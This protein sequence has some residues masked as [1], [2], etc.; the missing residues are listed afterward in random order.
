[1]AEASAER[2]SLVG[3][4]SVSCML[5]V[6]KYEH[7]VKAAHVNGVYCHIG[8]H[9]YMYIELAESTGK[10]LAKYWTYPWLVFPFIEGCPRQ[11]SFPH[12]VRH[13]GK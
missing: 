1:M 13:T 3:F 5:Q 9:C 8:M 4:Y 6:R 7:E 12:K 11:Y 2:N 10:H